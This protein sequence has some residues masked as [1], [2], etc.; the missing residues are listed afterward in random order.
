[1]TKLTD[2]EIKLAE[3]LLLSIKNM[4]LHIGYKELGDV[5]I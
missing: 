5:S 3:Q 1:M 2:K 4:E